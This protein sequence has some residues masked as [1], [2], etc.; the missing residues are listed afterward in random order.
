[1]L[2]IILH[3]KL[4]CSMQGFRYPFSIIGLIPS[5]THYYRPTH[6]LSSEVL[7]RDAMTGHSTSV[8]VPCSC[9][10]LLPSSIPQKEAQQPPTFWPMSIRGQTVAHLSYC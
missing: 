4:P 1:M 8:I 6:L 10:G 7:I 2:Y 9:F 3:T 5:I